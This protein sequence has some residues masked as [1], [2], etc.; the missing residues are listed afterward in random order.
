MNVCLAPGWADLL[1]R[2]AGIVTRHQGL[3]LGFT[4]DAIEN[5]VRSGQWRPIHRGVYA[6]FGGEP[7]RDAELWAVV[8]RA[9]PRAALSHQTA[10]E[11]I[12]LTSERS[13]L[14]HV[15]VPLSRHPEPIRGA[16]VHRSGRIGHATHP[17]RLPPRTRTEDTVIDL[18]QTAAVL[19]DA[20]GWLCRAVGQRLTTAHRLRATL[21]ARPRVRWRT[22]LYAALSDVG[23]GAHSLLEHRYIRDV[24]RAHG[25]PAATRQARTAVGGRISYLDNLYAAAGLAVEL[26]GGVAHPAQQ[27]WADMHRDNAHSAAGIVTLRYCWADITLRPCEVAHQVADALRQRGS[28]VALRH[29]RLLCTISP[30]AQAEPSSS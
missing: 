13:A 6:T 27:R 17:A 10:A 30:L 18:T 20:C 23:S 21:D 11:L 22:D 9:G 14:I 5:K 24:E 19:D 3:S 25:L 7:C 16:L 28:P 1:D 12:G 29:C 8:L 2:Q 15:T 26:D 4:E